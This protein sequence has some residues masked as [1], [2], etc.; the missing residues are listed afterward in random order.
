MTIVADRRGE[1]MSRLY[2]RL[3]LLETW[4]RPGVELVVGDP[5]Q[6]LRQRVDLSPRQAEALRAA[7]VVLLAKVKTSV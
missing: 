1:S 3:F 7:L 5:D 6:T 2:L 4:R